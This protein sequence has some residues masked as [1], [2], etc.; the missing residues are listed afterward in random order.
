MKINL[1]LAQFVIILLITFAL[2]VLSNWAVRKFCKKDFLTVDFLI[3]LLS[4]LFLSL[5]IIISTFGLLE[6]LATTAM[7]FFSSIIFSWLLTKENSKA[8]LKAQEQELAKKSYRHINYL[9]TAADTA[10][11]TLDQYITSQDSKLTAEVRLVLSRAM[12]QIGYIQGGINTC[13]MDWADLLSKEDQRKLTKQ[14]NPEDY[15]T[16]T[17]DASIPLNQEDV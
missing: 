12:D 1:N 2:G 11:K 4:L 6:E 15:G 17:V 14:E 3:I 9:E 16:T 13:K 10:G 8:D 5:S 7:T